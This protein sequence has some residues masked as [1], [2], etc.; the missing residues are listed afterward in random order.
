LVKDTLTIE[1]MRDEADALWP[2]KY[3]LD[4]KDYHFGFF[5]KAAIEEGKKL[6]MIKDPPTKGWHSILGCP[7]VGIT[8]CI[9]GAGSV[10]MFQKG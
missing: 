9:E 1:G 3:N 4:G 8:N 10:L 2:P 6:G 7:L 5:P